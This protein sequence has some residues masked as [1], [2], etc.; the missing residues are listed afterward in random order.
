MLTIN[1]NTCYNCGCTHE[2]SNES[3]DCDGQAYSDHYFGS[4]TFF[5][6]TPHAINVVGVGNIPSDGVLR[7]KTEKKSVKTIGGIPVVRT[8]FCE[9]EGYTLP[10]QDNCGFVH[11]IVSLPCAQALKGLRTD[12]LITDDPVR[13]DQGRIIGCKGL[14]IL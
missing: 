10:E 11:Y 5:N 7:V 9:L 14:G 12:I 3:P 13:D 6:L 8:I 2:E 1:K 4:D